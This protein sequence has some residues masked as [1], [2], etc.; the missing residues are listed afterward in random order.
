MVEKIVDNIIDELNKYDIGGSSLL[1]SYMFNQCVPKSEIVKGFLYRW[2][3]YCL[4]VWIKC[5]IKIYDFAEMQ[6]VKNFD[7]VKIPSP[8]FSMEKP[9]HLE[10]IDPNY[11]LFYSQLQNFNKK[12]YYK[13]APHIVKKCIKSVERKY[14]KVRLRFLVKWCVKLFFCRN[15]FFA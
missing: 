9:D 11:E 7:M 2:E 10:N 13:N 4:H 8:Q 5:D 12:T 14:A 1:A 6:K 3:F 15:V